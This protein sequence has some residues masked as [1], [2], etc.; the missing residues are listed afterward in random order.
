MGPRAHIAQHRHLR[1]RHDA[2]R[3]Y[4][5]LEKYPRSPMCHQESGGR[6]RVASFL[7]DETASVA[8][9]FA[10]TLRSRSSDF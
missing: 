2:Q 6:S 10:K 1:G 5:L 4:V 8:P 3:I 9:L 7:L